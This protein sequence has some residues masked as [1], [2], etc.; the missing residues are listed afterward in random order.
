MSKQGQQ[1]FDAQSG[2]DETWTPSPDRLKRIL[3]EHQKWVESD[4]RE[5][6]QANLREANLQQSGLSNANLRDA[7]L[8]GANL[9]RASLYKAKLQKA[10]LYKANLQDANLKE[11]NLQEALLA[12]A[13][14]QKAKLYQADLQ[15]T[16]L[17]G[18]N[19]KEATLVL[20]NL[21]KADLLGANLQ[22]ANLQDANLED[23][24]GLQVQQLRGANVSNAKLPED[25]AKFEGLDIIKDA[26]Q[27]A[28]KLFFSIL[29]VCVYAWLTI[30]TTEHVNLFVKTT[31]FQLPIIGTTIPIVSFYWMTP[32]ILL[33]LYIYFHMQ[34]QRL[35]EEL[36]SLPAIFPD[37]KPLD[38]KAYPWLLNGLVRAHVH[39]LKDAHIPFFPMQKW[40]I[41]LTAWWVVPITLAAFSYR[42]LVRHDAGL[43]GFHILLLIA[44]VWLAIAFYL[45]AKA[46]LCGKTRNE[47]LVE[48]QDKQW[49][50]GAAVFIACIAFWAILFFEPS[51]LPNAD[52]REVNLKG[53]DLRG[54]RMEGAILFNAELQMAR[55][56]NAQLQEAVL[57]SAQLDSAKLS[58]AS[59]Q[60]ANLSE[61]QLQGAD[62]TR[63]NLRKARLN[64]AKLQKADLSFAQLQETFLTSAQLQGATLTGAKLDS[65]ILNFTQLQE[66]NIKV[67]QL[68]RTKSLYKAA[69][70]SLLHEQVEDECPRLL[71][72]KPAWLEGDSLAISDAS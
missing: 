29:A 39:H 30:G 71:L 65:A 38:K 70:D 43:S 12:G 10:N 35:W 66:A 49:Q 36:A 6:E 40:I 60:K 42:Y 57:S 62:L 28:R 54:S 2:A 64:S 44:T 1:P 7:D 59:L 52:L 5:G 55:L 26:S 11:V 27:I 33:A 13:N 23:V 67:E 51:L 45:N 24:N 17:V 69:L 25:V 41:I 58:H 34:L 46:T 4:G 16:A 61:A 8:K 68:C 9:Q 19:L 47:S 22:D 20:A 15:K 37:G 14:L 63:A 32:L 3:Q 31:S 56:E 53:A 48:W 72:K 21:Q 50:V 18:A